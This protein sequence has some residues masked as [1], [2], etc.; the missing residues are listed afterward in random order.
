MDGFSFPGIPFVIIGRNQKLGWS[1]NTNRCS[2]QEQLFHDRNKFRDLMLSTRKE[3]IEVYN[4]P[5][6]EVSW[7]ESDSC[8][9]V[10]PTL[11]SAAL[12]VLSSNGDKH[13]FLC[14]SSFQVSNSFQL[15][16]SLN[17]A[18]S[19]EEMVQAVENDGGLMNSLNLYFS[20]SNGSVGMTGRKPVNSSICSAQNVSPLVGAVESVDT[21]NW[22]ANPTE[23]FHMTTEGV[24][25]ASNPRNHD[26]ILDLL[27]N[28]SS[29]DQKTV[30]DQS[31][32][33]K[34]SPDLLTHLLKDNL[35][36]SA[37]H[38]STFIIY[39]IDRMIEV[40]EILGNSSL[41]LD[42]Q[43]LEQIKRQLVEFK[44]SHSFDNEALTYMASFQ[45]QFMLSVL[46]PLVP[47]EDIF[48]GT[49]LSAVFRKTTHDD[50]RYELFRFV[51]SISF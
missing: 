26:R 37:T 22:K 23:P 4:S 29:E 25:V 14:S 5:A 27:F 24:L 13:L 15:L 42:F 18:K 33:V 2:Q 47:L 6:V 48:L 8:R 19:A 20:L 12:S 36:L 30:S 49:N 16:P 46:K 44:T 9:D 40:K 11:D 41:T 35:S 32:S 10:L 17:F 43:K 1:F 7:V 38:T 39:L 45:Y 28:D 34:V 50:F 51:G 31:C 3:T 21:L